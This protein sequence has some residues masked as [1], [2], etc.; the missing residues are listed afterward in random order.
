MQQ[1]QAQAAAKLQL[2]QEELV[3]A[4]DEL[5]ATQ[6]ALSAAQS[7]AASALTE[8]GRVVIQCLGFTA[9][10]LNRTRIC[11]VMVV[12]ALVD[13]WLPQGL[14]KLDAHLASMQSFLEGLAMPQPPG[15]PDAM[16]GGP[17]QVGPQY[18]VL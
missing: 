1:D 17:L 3:A 6:R 9:R 11:V 4:R 16:G 5:V 14:T 12:E 7:P 18:R 10:V 2:S 13:V 15:V 8:V